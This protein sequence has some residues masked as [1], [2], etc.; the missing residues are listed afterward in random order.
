MNK[1]Q[2][3]EYLN[4]LREVK[5]QY[6]PR[7]KKL[8]KNHLINMIVELSTEITQ[9]RQHFKNQESEENSKNQGTENE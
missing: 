8:S 9:Y 3:E 7:L 6:K 1:E 4:L 5:K 2:A